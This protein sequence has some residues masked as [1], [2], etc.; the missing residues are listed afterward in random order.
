M[1][2]CRHATLR[3]DSLPERLGITPEACALAIL[4]G[5]ERNKATIVVTGFA[6]ILWLLHRIHPGLIFWM[7]GREIKKSRA[8]MRINPMI[9]S[10][11]EQWKQKSKKSQPG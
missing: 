2:T 1:L 10:G 3:K 5:V 8:E 7:M 4:R 11:Q 6:K 9:D